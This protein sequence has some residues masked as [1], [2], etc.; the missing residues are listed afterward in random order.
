MQA[1][2]VRDCVQNTKF[3]AS[4]SQC[5]LMPLA[6]P[7]VNLLFPICNVPTAPRFLILLPQLFLQ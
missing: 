7:H 6:T 4:P 3:I 5:Y 1:V 2:I